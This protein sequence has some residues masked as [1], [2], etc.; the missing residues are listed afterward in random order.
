ME[1]VEWITA[2]AMEK[3]KKKKK[4]LRRE[5]QRD[6]LREK[7]EWMFKE[8]GC[9]EGHQKKATWISR[10]RFPPVNVIFSQRHLSGHWLILGGKKESLIVS[11][12]MMNAFC[13]T[14][15]E[16]FVKWHTLVRSEGQE[17]IIDKQIMLKYTLDH[18]TGSNLCWFYLLFHKLIYFPH[19]FRL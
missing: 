8:Q 10:K 4:Q 12:C 19:Q 6:G 5:P 11:E 13:F 3:A 16:Q 7:S 15:E 9:E 1:W 2:V 14:L 18:F 17:T